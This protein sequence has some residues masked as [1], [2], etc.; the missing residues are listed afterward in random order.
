MATSGQN[1]AAVIFWMKV[2]AGWREKQDI[3]I[4]TRSIEQ[5]TDEELL[6]EIQQLD[7]HRRYGITADAIQVEPDNEAEP[8]DPPV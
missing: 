7:R 3:Q 1:V 6:A 5:M 4:S 8:S 2:R